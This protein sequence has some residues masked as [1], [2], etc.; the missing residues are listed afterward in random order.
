MPREDKNAANKIMNNMKISEYEGIIRDIGFEHQRFG[1]K[2]S[3]FS[4]G[5]STLLSSKDAKYSDKKKVLSSSI[6]LLETAGY[7][8]TE[9]RK[10][11][12]KITNFTLFEEEITK[13]LGT[14][15][16]SLS[17]LEKLELHADKI[18]N[19]DGYLDANSL[20][21]LF[22]LCTSYSKEY[23]YMSTQIS[24][25]VNAY[26]KTMSPSRATLRALREAGFTLDVGK[27]IEVVKGAHKSV[28]KNYG[29]L[30]E[31]SNDD[32]KLVEFFNKEANILRYEYVKKIKKLLMPKSSEY[33]KPIQ[34][35]DDYIRVKYPNLAAL[36]FEDK[37]KGLINVYRESRVV[38]EDDA[39]ALLVFSSFTS[40]KY[41]NIFSELTGCVNVYKEDSAKI[42]E[43]LKAK[44][45]KVDAFEMIR[46]IKQY[47]DFFTKG[48]RVS[49][50]TYFEELKNLEVIKL[51]DYMDY[52]DDLLNSLLPR[53]FALVKLAIEKKKNITPYDVQL[54]GAL[55]L[56]EGNVAQMCTGEGKTL[57]ALFSAFLNS[58]TGEEVDVYTP[59]DYLAERDAE[60]AKGILGLLG[61][62]VGC[63]LAAD[64][65]IKQK[66]LA[67]RSN[68]VYGSSSAFA[69]DLLKDTYSTKE[70]DTVQRVRK[71]YYAIIDEADRTLIDE[72]L[73]PFKLENAKRITKRDE[74]E[75]KE[76]V[77]Y[78]QTAYDYS[79]RL[80]EKRYSNPDLTEESDDFLRRATGEDLTVRFGLRFGTE[81]ELEEYNRIQESNYVI[82]GKTD[83]ALTY[84]GNIA[85]FSWYMHD[86]IKELDKQAAVYFK[87]SKD[88]VEGVHYEIVDGELSLTP[89]GLLKAVDYIKEYNELEKIWLTDPKCNTIRSYVK[90]QLRAFVMEKGSNDNGYDVIF[91]PETGREEIVILEA[92]RI[93][94][95]SKYERGLHQALELKEF[96]EIRLDQVEKLMD[97]SFDTITMNLLLYRY[98]K[99]SG[100]T[101]TSDKDLFSNVYMMDTVE[102]PR[103]AEYQYR[104]GTSTK[105]PKK[106]VERPTVLF[107]DEDKKIDAIANDVFRSWFSGQPVLVV[108]DNNDEARAIF[109]K[110]S[111]EYGLDDFMNLLISGKEDE[112][113]NIVA[114]AGKIGSITIASEMAGRG[115]DIR[116]IVDSDDARDL[117]EQ[118]AGFDLWVK[119]AYEEYRTDNPTCTLARFRELV[120]RNASILDHYGADFDVD[121]AIASDPEIKRSYDT[122]VE[123]LI[124]KILSIQQEKGLKYIQ[125]KPFKTM[126]ND[127]QARGRVGRQGEAGETRLY[128]CLNDLNDIG[129][130]DEDKDFLSILLDDGDYVVD[131]EVE[132]SISEVIERAQSNIE[133]TEDRTI[134][135]MSGVD[136]SIYAISNKF[137]DTRK[138]LMKTKDLSYTFESLMDSAL[139]TMIK[140]NLP[141]HKKKKFE[142]DKKIRLKKLDIDIL[143]KQVHDV[144]GISISEVTLK[145]ECRTVSEARDYV[146]GILNEKASHLMAQDFERFNSSIRSVL[147]EGLN[148]TYDAF[149]YSVESVREQ[150]FN[151]R[152]AQ[153]TR[154]NR[155][156]EVTDIYKEALR[157]FRYSS[158]RDIFRPNIK[159]KKGTAVSQEAT[160]VVIE[161]SEE[162]LT[163]ISELSKT[164]KRR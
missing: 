53:A 71:P 18:N 60:N 150:E 129:V 73:V 160:D 88:Y 138:K 39:V 131:N 61:V 154:H 38:P 19:E 148:R 130:S 67:Y 2:W 26:K 32:L 127:D 42:I 29:S 122:A 161:D 93:Q 109:E 146:K 66:K 30:A 31:A 75:N 158:L 20:Y 77:E 104:I 47:N 121:E 70:E 124:P 89:E 96:G 16:E 80:L 149:M 58:L 120:L 23:Y 136:F 144:F 164:I 98:G 162:N 6:Y 108:T 87:A 50:L 134:A 115:T 55:A 151:D 103:N 9:L 41:K 147:S 100:M 142:R 76:I 74:E 128:A 14:D 140:D 49:D 12:R 11:L 10:L 99:I 135:S 33:L 81:D 156:N 101:G 28:D 126:R 86:Q 68:V 78:L 54:M 152:L 83:A 145:R 112:E 59:N 69:F 35:L 105:K 116:L 37:L 84:L 4:N 21:E 13:K 62:Q 125:T 163:T 79:L 118:I 64:Q 63:T 92:G 114:E 107:R 117:A 141:E 8:C 139:S 45:L 153:N 57:T 95:F 123:S 52:T 85:L 159:S 56:N 111:A 113:A 94:K 24:S 90:T 3:I 43:A 143:L 119:N 110:L 40:S 157:D 27:M 7:D 36:S 34:K 51:D 44:K 97:S 48:F 82:L 5:N 72:A 25:I 22:A 65:E 1:T 106:V 15:S 137:L 102:I 155:I 46:S 132:G 17:F 133:L 91:N